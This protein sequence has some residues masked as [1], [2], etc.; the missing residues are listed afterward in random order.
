MSIF[1]ATLLAFFPKKY[2]EPFSRYA[3]PPAGALVGGA[4]ETIAALL[5]LMQRYF[6]FANQ[7]LAAIQVSVMTGAAA[8][9]GESAVMGLGPILML[10]YL[11]Q[12]TTLVLIFIALEGVIRSTAAV[13]N[14]ETLPSL[15]L[16]ALAQLQTWLGAR[17]RESRLGRRLADDVQ[18]AADGES[19]RIASCRPKVWTAL[20]TISYEDGL[21]ELIAEE[22]SALP[23]QFVYVLRKKPISGVIRGIHAYDPQEVLSGK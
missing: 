21:Y 14:A 18:L 19:L 10:E 23:R 1:A 8:K 11:L 20:T 22:K 17:N 7:R 16:E 5:L 15:P 13:I 12:I 3:V 9:G 2:R 6:V 4:A